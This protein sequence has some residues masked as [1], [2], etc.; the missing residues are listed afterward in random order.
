MNINPDAARDIPC[1]NVLIY[2][3]CKFENKGCAFSH[4]N[5][6][7]QNTSKTSTMKSASGNSVNSATMASSS[8]SEAA[9]STA[10]STHKAASMANAEPK[11]KFNMNT[12]LFQPSV[13]AI[14]NKF[15]TLS[16][17]LKEIPVFVPSSGDGA[18]SASTSVTK[19]S[20]TAFASRK[21]NTSTPSFTPLNP[22]D[23]P[24]QYN[25]APNDGYVPLDINNASSVHNVQ[26]LQLGPAKQQNPYLQPSGVIPTPGGL[27]PPG[28][29]FRFLHT[30][31]ALAYPLN[32]HLYAPAPPPRFSMQLKPHETT[33]NAMFV[34]NDLRELL[35]R[36]NE[37]TL[38]TM[39]QLSLPEHVGVYHSLVPIDLS[40]DSISKQYQVPSH[41]YKVISNVDGAHYA[42]RTIDYSSKLRILNE[43]PFSTVKKWKALKNANVVHLQDA[44]TSAG[45]IT[46][47]D[48]MLC[49]VYDFYP[50]ANT[51][52]EHHLTR[53]LGGKLE[54][55]TEDTL[56][57]YLVQLTNALLAIHN[58]G[59]SAGSSVSLSKILVTNKNRVRLGAVCVDDILEHEA[60]EIRK[61]EVGTDVALRTLQIGDII[62]LGRVIKE[63]ASATLP[64]SLR[65]GPF[66]STLSSLRSS[67]TVPLSEEFLAV[68]KVLNTV[69]DNFDLLQFY[70]YHL[71][72]RTLGLLNGLQDLTDFYESQ[73]LSE[74]EN[75][76]LFRLMAKINYV[77][78]RRPQDPEL[79]GSLLVINLF[80]DFVF[81]TCNEFGKP[82][83]DLSKVLTNLN[84]LDAGVDEKVLLISREEDSCIIVS[85]KEVKDIIDLTFRAIFR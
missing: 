69:D 83:A 16:P 20:S 12:P 21:F 23:A 85:Y 44:F 38:Q 29:D 36:K 25:G 26:N 6:G 56:W 74:V 67:S 47:G 52:Q 2:G 13:L 68:L 10:P 61:E 72:Q 24:D 22:F 7:Q 19:D 32:Y 77:V 35:T 65:G 48:P 18:A 8:F 60:I 42:M 78:D 81:Q 14:T 30:L 75:G 80:R 46:Q 82:V 50:L 9:D 62:R 27:M 53:K 1:K 59:L 63:L 58:A 17:K 40:F 64:V 4:P 71:S 41:I 57:V 5:L 37:A 15:A 45:F 66:E 31:G 39:S 28:S 79:S 3:Y 84:K 54:P 34:P 73:L 11:R 70:N 51:L 55:I 49:L 76:R 43:L 33:A